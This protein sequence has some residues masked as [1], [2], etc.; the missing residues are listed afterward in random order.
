MSRAL[1][2]Q[3]SAE[4]L[5][6]GM[7]EFRERGDATVFVAERD[8]GSLAGF[9]EVGARPYADGCDTSPVGYIEAWYVDP[10][11]RRRGF[12]R[13][14]LAAAEQWAHDRGYR[15]M[16]SDSSLDNVISHA[17]HRRA[18]YEEVDRVMQFRK[19]LSENRERMTRFENIQ[20]ILRVS[21]IQRSVKY[22]VGILGFTKAPWGDLFT[23]VGRD[24]CGIYLCQGSQGQ[25]GTW[26]WAGVEDVDA[27]YEEY[28]A[29]GAMIRLPPRNYPWALE[30]HV[31]DPDGHVLRFGSEPKSDRPFDKF[32]E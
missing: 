26:V 22:Y 19:T 32:V 25:P 16:A 12:G 20:P 18:G 13:A 8:D 21:D 11:V 2:P 30:M 1:F 6:D 28:K 31:E 23:A 29:S 7:R 14:L 24:R 3:H 17:A 15:E 10:D 27:L 4:N 5:E 9:V